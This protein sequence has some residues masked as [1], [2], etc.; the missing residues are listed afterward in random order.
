MAYLSPMRESIPTLAGLHLAHRGKVRD[1]YELFGNRRLIVATDAISIFDFVLNALVPGKGAILN[2]LSHHWLAFLESRGIATHMIAAGARIDAY[3]P[4]S[5]QGNTELQTRAMVARNLKMI[6]IEFI[7]RN[8]LTGS[9]LSQYRKSGT[10]YGHVLPAG[11]H[12]GDR[13]K[14]PL[15]TPTTKAEEGHDEP[16]SEEY[17]RSEYPE[18]TR[19]FLHAFAVITAEAWSK[20][21]VLADSKG[22]LD[23]EGCIGD[24]FGTPDSSRFWDLDA[25]I[26]SR[27]ANSRTAPTPFD[28]QMVRAWGIERGINTLDPTNPE[29]VK[30]VH[31]LDV[32]EELLQATADIYRTIFQKLTGFP[33][34]EYQRRFLGISV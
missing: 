7:A 10:V 14:E 6:P 11:L 18:A 34:E 16:M 28:K 32:P 3:L 15:F 24:E 2:A 19:T 33:L 4:E 9:A 20:G 13:L 8:C 21:I 29:H 25:W 1:S 22:E 17:V 5:I 12:D 30:H 23:T 31:D 27:E 26:T